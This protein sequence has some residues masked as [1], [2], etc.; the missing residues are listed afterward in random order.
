MWD[1]FLLLL[2]LP[3]A[4]AVLSQVEL[5]LW[6]IIKKQKFSFNFIIIFFFFIPIRE[7]FYFLLLIVKFIYSKL[8]VG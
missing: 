1:L 4:A 3:E 2:F 7:D 8:E 6:I 5:S